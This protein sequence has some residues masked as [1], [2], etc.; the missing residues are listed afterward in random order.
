VIPD[1]ITALAA[2][3]ALGLSLYNFVT[4]RRDRYPRFQITT[5]TDKPKISETRYICRIVNKGSV[6]AKIK[7]VRLF[8]APSWRWWLRG[9]LGIG[10]SVPF[11]PA[12]VEVEATLGDKR[13]KVTGTPRV[14]DSPR[15]G[16]PHDLPLVGD[17]V[18]FV[19]GVSDMRQALQNAGYSG[20]SAKFRV[21]VVD[22]LDRAHGV[23]D[24]LTLRSAPSTRRGV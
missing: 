21:G 17:E 19:A 13:E 1:W 12:S 22:A 2:V 3:A 8:L 10:R 5:E 6:P 14:P 23:K 9:L 16:L 7:N 18:R 20:A 15:W 24:E 11:P 4:Q